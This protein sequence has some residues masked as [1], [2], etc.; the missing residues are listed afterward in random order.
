MFPSLNKLHCF[1][2]RWLQVSLDLPSAPSIILIST[3]C[4]RSCMSILT[5]WQTPSKH[6]PTW[7]LSVFHE[8]P[9]SS[10]AHKTQHC[11]YKDIGKVYQSTLDQVPCSGETLDRVGIIAL[12]LSYLF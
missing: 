8:M 11:K 6:S 2:L 9:N 7:L 5:K 10:G 3:S 4:N 1:F 12:V